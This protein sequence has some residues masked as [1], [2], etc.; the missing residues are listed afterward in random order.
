[1]FK[2]TRRGFYSEVNNLLNAVT[3]SLAT[4][5]R[6]IVDETDF[7]GLRWTEFF[8]A[9]LPSAPASVIQTVAPEWVIEG[10][11]AR[12]F[13]TISTW[14]AQRHRDRLPVSLPTLGIFGHLFS[15]KR[16]LAAV[17]TAPRHKAMLPEGLVPPFAAFH[18]RRGDKVNG[19]LVGDELVIEGDNVPSSA[20]VD[21]LE[22]KAPNVRSIFVMADDHRSVDELRA[23]AGSR[24][25]FTLCSPSEQGYK[26]SDFSANT[27]QNK[28]DCLQRLLQETQIA[29]SSAVFIGGFKSNVARFVPLWHRDPRM[30]FS[31]DGQRQWSPI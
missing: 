3:Y 30:C 14:A 15:V 22:R 31:I 2:L 18:I 25:V 28:A 12:H 17:L 23:V 16:S 24:R 27:L 5:R 6:L 1:V 20:Y 8:S 26:Q 29:A 21:M 7:E 11:G 10:G 13:W 4:R 9:C 19:Y